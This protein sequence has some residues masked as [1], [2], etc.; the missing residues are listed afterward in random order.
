MTTQQSPDPTP[1]T[2][3]VTPE[4][5]TQIAQYR[6][7]CLPEDGIDSE[8]FGI[9]VEYRGKGRWAV[10]RLSS[11]LGADGTWSWGHDWPGEPT[12]DQYEAYEA[13]RQRWLDTHRFD[14]ETALRLAREAA[15]HVTVNG[16]TV[17][18]AIAMRQ[19]RAG[20][21]Q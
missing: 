18:D 5:T 4:P 1:D 9:T 17:A 12:S 11:Y 10:V 15:P 14:E 21:Q 8:L 7:N 13:S 16:F 3:V 20:K 19:R 6:I 2:A